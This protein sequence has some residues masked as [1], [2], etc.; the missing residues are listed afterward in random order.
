MIYLRKKFLAKWDVIREERYHEAR[1]GVMSG[2]PEITIAEPAEVEVGSPQLR[3][4]DITRGYGHGHIGHDSM[5][6]IDLDSPSPTGRS[7]VIPP[8]NPSPNPD[9]SLFHGGSGPASNPPDH[10]ASNPFINTSVGGA[11]ANPYG[12]YGQANPYGMTGDPWAT[13]TTTTTTGRMGSHS[14]TA[15]QQQQQPQ[16]PPPPNSPGFWSDPASPSVRS[17]N[18]YRMSDVSM[19]SR[20]SGSPRGN[21]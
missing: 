17:R 11:G 14:S 1:S 6:T 16:L 18:P 9:F 2:V 4:W 19:L 7:F 8:L 13:T 15:Q 5:G 10:V 3:T 20:G 21:S 12:T